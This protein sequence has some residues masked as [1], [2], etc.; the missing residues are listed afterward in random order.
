M[1]LFSVFDSDIPGAPTLSPPVNIE[2]NT[3]GNLVKWT[4]PDDNGS[5]LTGYRI[6]RGIVGQGEKLIA[7]V[8]TKTNVFSYRDKLK[9]GSGN[10]YYHVTAVNRFGESP[11]NAKTFVKGS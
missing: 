2:S 3:D 1:R 9:K 11:R 10:Y 6:Y 8:K 4:M 5:P 7:E